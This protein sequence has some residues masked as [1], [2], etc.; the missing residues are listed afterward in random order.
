MSKTPAPEFFSPSVTQ[1]RRF[2]L[3]LA[4]PA[5]QPLAVVC[6]GYER[7]S[8]E[9]AI[10]RDSFPYFSIELVERGK[11]QVVLD[12]EAYALAAGAVF[13]YGPGVV[14]RIRTDRRD[15]LRKYFVNFT[16]AESHELLESAGLSLASCAMVTPL[17]EVQVLFNELLR[18][19][20]TNDSLSGPM[21]SALLRSI[22][23]RICAYQVTATSNQSESYRSYQL[24]VAH[25]DR[26]A[27][28]LTSVAQV[29][30]DCGLDPS[31]LARLFKRHGRQTPYRYLMRVRMNLAAEMLLDSNLAVAEVASIMG[32]ED[33]F[34][35][36]RSFKSTFG[37]SP[38][39]FRTMR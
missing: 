34:H 30:T 31:Y 16:G 2:F 8:P 38:T 33:P 35:F 26:H 17:A 37:V 36:S 25:I 29:A 21:C 18:D 32:C 7:C 6:G 15:R 20:A 1:Q 3:D 27:R 19:G 5:N 12:G 4:P 11:G 13:A 9:Y 24:C 28:R 10:D 22:C 23:L 39:L 14:H